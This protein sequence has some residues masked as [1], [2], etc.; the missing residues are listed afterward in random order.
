MDRPTDRRTDRPTDGL[1]L[2]LR[3]VD[4]SKKCKSSFEINRPDRDKYIKVYEEKIAKERRY[5]Y[6]KLEDLNNFGIPYDIL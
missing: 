4:P 1:T 2:I 5:S 3:W 6:T